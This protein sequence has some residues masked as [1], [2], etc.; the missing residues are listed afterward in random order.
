MFSDFLSDLLA[1]LATLLL[2]K[3]ASHVGD[4]FKP[5]LPI[6]KLKAQAPV[7][8][9]RKA[10]VR[11]FRDPVNVA[12]LLVASYAPA[13]GVWGTVADPPEAAFN[14]CG[15]LLAIALAYHGVRG[16]KAVVRRLRASA[17]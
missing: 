15:A 14:A 13:V 1:S 6:L 16:V 5:R 3:A 7:Q 11:F 8:R 10:T 12:A 2:S 17:A 4:F 9:M